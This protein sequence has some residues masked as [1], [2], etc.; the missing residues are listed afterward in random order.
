MY[1]CFDIALSYL[2]PSLFGVYIIFNIMLLRQASSE[3]HYKQ[4]IFYPH[5]TYKIF[6]YLKH[7][8][9]MITKTLGG[10]AMAEQF[11]LDITNR[12]V[13]ITIFHNV[14]ENFAAEYRALLSG[15]ADNT[16]HDTTTTELDWDNMTPAMKSVFLYDFIGPMPAPTVPTDIP[17]KKK[18][19]PELPMDSDNPHIAKY[20]VYN[21]K[22]RLKQ[23]TEQFRTD[24]YMNFRVPN[25][26]FV[27]LTFDPNTFEKA[28]DLDSCH[29]A[30]KKF[31]QRVHYTLKDFVYV[32]TFSRQK[33]NNWHYHMLCNLDINVKNK[34]I[35][36][37]W[38]YGLTHSTPL[39]THSEFSSRISYCIDNMYAVAWEDLR[40]EK[41][42]LKSKGL[43][44]RV[45]LRSWKENETDTAYEYLSKILESTD[46]PLDVSSKEVTDDLT[47]DTVRITR[48]FSHKTFPELF[49]NVKVAKFKR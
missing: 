3:I 17:Q 24:A 21:Y 25:V 45:V 6:Y 9:I 32:A 7:S 42:C 40:G 27:T 43:L 49:E 14:S 22:K 19:K 4:N 15:N 2:S 38:S 48:K 13:R 31:I 23:R 47:N 37:K 36:D 11:K 12:G 18:V 26:Q 34:F 8:A 30:F 5:D 44:K 29:K 41:G 28:D 10:I 1:F 39:T 20:A 46:K 33:N 35:Q 16:S